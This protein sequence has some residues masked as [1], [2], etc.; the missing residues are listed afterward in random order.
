MASYSSKINVSKLK[1]AIDREIKRIGIKTIEEGL[2]S[3]DKR[4]IG[5]ELIE[6]IKDQVSKGISP[7][8]GRGRFEGYK[9]VTKANRILRGGKGGTKASRARRRKL[10]K[11]TKKQ[12]Y[13]YSVKNKFP[14]KRE[15][16]V[17][18]FLSGRFLNDLRAKPLKRGLEFGFYTK[19]STNKELGHREGANT[20]PER[21]I[22]PV[23]NERLNRTIYNRLIVS[24]ARR[25]KQ[26][27]GR[28]IKS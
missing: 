19:L 22:I 7:I 20:Q 12:G 3:S 28:A 9:A 15:R 23:R 16:P 10:A 4:E 17:N 11:A 26:A 2:T 5:D 8:L 6:A 1:K 24:L 14:S 13:P 18:L 27:I 25:I 21:P